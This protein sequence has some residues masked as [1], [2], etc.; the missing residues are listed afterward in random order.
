MTTT[1]VPVK[2][3]DVAEVVLNTPLPLVVL[4]RCKPVELALWVGLRWL[5][6]AFPEQR[7]FSSRLIAKRAKIS[8]AGITQHFD[9][10][11]ELRLITIVGKERVRNGR[12]RDVYSID[13]VALN[14]ET[15]DMVFEVLAYCGVKTPPDRPPKEQLRLFDADG[16]EG[17]GSKLIHSS[18]H[19][20]AVNQTN[21]SIL[22][23]RPKTNGS[24]LIHSAEPNGSKTSHSLE[25]PHAVNQTNGSKLIH[26]PAANTTEVIHSTPKNRRPLINRIK[27]NRR[28]GD[29]HSLTERRRGHFEIPIAPPGE[30]ALMA[31]PIDVWRWAHA[32]A[33]AN[34]EVRLADLAAAHDVPISAYPGG[35]GSYWLGRAMLA[36]IESD[37]DLTIPYLKRILTS[38]R[39][40]TTDTLNAYGSDAPAYQQ[41]QARNRQ[42]AAEPPPPA[43]PPMAAAPPSATLTERWQQALATIRAQIPDSAFTTWFAE[44]TLLDLDDTTAIVGTANI[45]ARDHLQQHYAALITAALDGRAIEFV[46]G[47]G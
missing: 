25:H 18:P 36:A 44:T 19:S 33:T 13:L 42:Q 27:W 39:R 46:I 17:N 40:R 20:N 28:E 24:K 37:K 47:G 22:I 45:F 41:H 6:A 7:G 8:R 29:H 35:F 15:N 32:D 31:H 10:L 43:P 9:R 23:H 21:G 38:W 11:L 3:P 30:R 5:M 34:D 16:A 14:R 1:F 4:E 2:A 12:S 26:S